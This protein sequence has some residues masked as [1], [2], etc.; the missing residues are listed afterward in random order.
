M[1]KKYDNCKKFESHTDPCPNRENEALATVRN[2]LPGG[3]IIYHPGNIFEE[4]KK[5]CAKCS[6]FVQK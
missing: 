3:A 2:L 5:I 4:A 6:D 1:E